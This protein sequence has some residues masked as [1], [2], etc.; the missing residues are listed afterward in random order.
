MI[1]SGFDLVCMFYVNFVVFA[2]F[3]PLDNTASSSELNVIPSLRTLLANKSSLKAQADTDCSQ[4]VAQP[5]NVTLSPTTDKPEGESLPATPG[6][7]IPVI[8]IS[9]PVKT[10]GGSPR[11]G[12][13]T[14]GK[15]PEK[16]ATSPRRQPAHGPRIKHVCRRAAVALGTPATFPSPPNALTLSALPTQE[17]QKILSERDKDERPGICT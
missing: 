15:T 7:A 14:P 12:G 13:T 2:L 9:S 11:A 17:K 6:P 5:V 16:T 3:C 8:D 4:D 10:P 1:S